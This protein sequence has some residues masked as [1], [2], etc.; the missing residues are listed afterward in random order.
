[1]GAPT[2]VLVADAHPLVR[3]AVRHVLSQ[4]AAFEVIAEAG[5]V[6][7]AVRYI[8]EVPRRTDLIVTG[9]SFPDGSG[10]T[11]VERSQ[12][13]RPPVPVLVL[14]AKGAGSPAFAASVLRAGAAGFVPKTASPESVLRAVQRVARGGRVV[15]EDVVD[16]LYERRREGDALS[17]RELDVLRLL[18]GGMDSAEIG[19]ALNLSAST[20]RTYRHRVREKLGLGT[21]AELTRYAVQEGIA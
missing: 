19:R 10:A 2:R 18:A 7:D 17:M 16:R 1:M 9:M 5:S 13:E 3:L 20:V 21:V 14:S 15:P 4:D 8:A 11:L 12:G 6:L